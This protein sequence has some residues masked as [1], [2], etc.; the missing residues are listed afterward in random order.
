MEIAGILL[1]SALISAVVGAIA[2]H[3]S[4][5]RLAANQAQ[6]DYELAAKKRLYEALGPLRFQLLVAARDVVRRV[7]PHRTERWNMTP[8]GFYAGSFI[9]RLLR[10]LA[11]AE[12]VERQ[13]AVVDF[14]VDPTGMELLRFEAAAYRMLTS[15][16]PLPYHGH[17]DWS[18][19][20]QH[21]FRDNLR[22]A[23]SALIAVGPDGETRVVDYSEFL[24]RQTVNHP[25]LAPVRRLFAGCSHNLTENAVWWVRIV[26]Y[27]YA[28]QWLLEVQGK[29]LGFG[30]QT[31]DVKAMI[32]AVKDAE[33]LTHTGDYP[34]VY[35]KVIAEML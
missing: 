33:V 2:G 3:F 9:Y 30:V 4:Q 19:E 18:R 10:P 22:L 27:A 6:I 26:G 28:C 7:R 21:V 14:S 5:R 25:A 24:E 34:A 12:L 31:L 16:D 32:A 13:M 11:L 35:D 20:T 15:S 29:Q 1:S 23:A 8:D 17:L